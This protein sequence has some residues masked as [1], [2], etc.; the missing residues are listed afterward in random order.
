[1]TTSQQKDIAESD[2]DG[3]RS[4]SLSHL[5]PIVNHIPDI[6]FIYDRHISRVIYCNSRVFDILGY[7]SVEFQSMRINEP[8]AFIH[9]EDHPEFQIC[10]GKIFNAVGDSV[11]EFR[12]RCRQKSGQ[13]LWMKVKLSVFERDKRENPVRLIG[14]AAD[15]STEVAAKE[16]LQRRVQLLELTLDSMSEGVIVCDT[17]GDLLMIN[18]S[19][20]QILQI[21]STLSSVSQIRSAYT[22]YHDSE[23]LLLFWN[24]HPLIRALAGE[25]VQ[26][27]DLSLFDRKRNLSL[28]LNHASAPLVDASGQIIGAVDVFRDSTEKH[29]TFYE[30]KR[31]EE[32]FRLLVEGTTDYAIFMLDQDGLVVSWNPGAERIIGFGKSEIIGQHLSV[33]FTPEDQAKGEPERKLSEASQQGRAEEDGW[34]V[35]KDGHRFWCSGVTGALRDTEVNLKGFVVI[36]RD[37]TERRLVDQNNFFLANHDALTGLPNRARFLERLHEALINADRDRTRVAVLLLDLDRF[38]AINDTLGHHTGDQFLK[39]VSKRLT[40]CVRETDTVARLGGDEFVLILTRLKSLSSAELIAENVIHELSKPYTIDNHEVN[41]GASVGIAFYPQDGRD[42]GELLQK[43]DLAM[44]RAKATG[45]GRYRVFAP[46]MLTEVQQ[47]RQQEEQLRS[48]V[49]Q[50][51]FD[52]VYQPQID[53]ET[54]QITGVEALLRC[55]NSQLM[56]L[57]TRQIIALAEEMGLICSVGTWVLDLACSQLAHWRFLAA[58]GA[59]NISELSALKVSVNIAPAQLLADTFMDSLKK[60]L[61]QYDLPATTLEIEITEASLVSAITSE[62]RVIDELKSLGV[63]ISIDDFGAG[64]SSLSYLKQFPVDVL[65][66]DPGLISNLPRDHEDAAIVSAIIRLASDLH[67]KVVA[68]GV[69]NFD[70]LGFLRS[71][72]CQCVQGFLFSEAVRP[73]KFMQLLQNRKSGGRI[74]H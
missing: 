62:S 15:V 45:R 40:E 53:L 32:Q 71:T 18:Q 36:L 13:W 20:R 73:D 28:T 55:R 51:D 63:S 5:D 35:R 2:P 9:T 25:K 74:I 57:S 19:A 52:L 38:K 14:T 1:L 56:A 49:A 61:A 67:I 10:L 68:E 39:L 72:P 44:Y 54:L 7:S 3:H 22:T 29:R 58:S 12:G 23:S 17:N 16:S 41:S 8:D 65:K 4:Q 47:R 34:R 33:F 30:L 48:A 59:S 31:T 6:F 43:A 60:I 50:G 66:L 11:I 64:M 21:D 26:D 69:E 70:Q 27:R 42:S 46:G 37:N 24:H